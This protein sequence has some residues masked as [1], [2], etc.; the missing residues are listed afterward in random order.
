ME[1]SCHVRD[2]MTKRRT[3]ASGVSGGP[4]PSWL[5]NQRG[6]SRTVSANRPG[7]AWVQGPMVRRAV[8][9]ARRSAS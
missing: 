1:N 8:R 6:P 3:G 2:P 9:P 4:D 5:S 7:L